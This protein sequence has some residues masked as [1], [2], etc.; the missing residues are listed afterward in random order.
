MGNFL[1]LIL[2]VAL[3]GL[4]SYLIVE[5]LKLRNTIK[6][7]KVQLTTTENFNSNNIPS[8]IDVEN[9]I[10]EYK[11]ELSELHSIDTMVAELETHLH[12]KDTSEQNENNTQ[13]T[14][15]II[16][17]DENIDFETI[18][19]EFNEQQFNELEDNDE[20]EQEDNDESEQKTTECNDSSNVLESKDTHDDVVD[21][22][23][24]ETK[25]INFFL[26]KYNKVELKTLCGDNNLSKGGSKA[27]LI[28]KLLNKNILQKELT[29]TNILYNLNINVNEKPEL[30]Q[31][32]ITEDVSNIEDDDSIEEI[33]SEK[34]NDI[35]IDSL[36]Y[37]LRQLNLTEVDGSDNT[38]Y[39]QF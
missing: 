1:K 22:I 20:S 35:P 18:E 15:S 2:G 5:I 37:N 38:I 24:S 4:F 29:T 31:E 27:E 10:S 32:N 19:K 8:N 6:I 9:E 14:D 7:L 13:D 17:E 34:T 16:L 3:L 25:D 39:A 23:S 36:L 30:I 12:N 21:S 11:K 33:K 28:K 26:S